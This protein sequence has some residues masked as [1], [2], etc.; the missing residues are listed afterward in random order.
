MR[1]IDATSKFLSMILRH[2][3]QQLDLNK[4]RPQSP[5]FSHGVEGDID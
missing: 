3:P 5:D 1:D 2:K 4:S